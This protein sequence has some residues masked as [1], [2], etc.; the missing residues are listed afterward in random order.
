MLGSEFKLIAHFV[1]KIDNVA[2]I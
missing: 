1:E 2:Y